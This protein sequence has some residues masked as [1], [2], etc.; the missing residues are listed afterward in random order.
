MCGIAGI[1]DFAGRPIGEDLLEAMA[2]SLRHRGPDDA[3]IWRHQEDG[4]SAGLAHARLAVIDP[5][6]QGHQP[7]LDRTGRWAITYNGELYNYRA[8]AARLPQPLRTA[9][10]T[11]VALE[12]CAAW[13]A[14]ALAAFDGMWAMAVVNPYDRRGHLSRDP[15]GIKPLFY[16]FHDRRLVFGSEL[17]ALRQVAD[18]PWDIDEQALA[19]Y[20]RLGWIP[21][22]LTIYRQVRK[23]APGHLLTFDA[24]GPAEPTRFFRLP[25]PAD[26][27]PAYLDACE[28]VRS[29]V[30]R[31][32]ESQ[33]VADVPLG[34][35]LSGGLDSS[36]VVACLARAC[37]RPV[38]TFSIGYP[39][40]DRY[41]ETGYARMVARH[42]GTEHQEIRLS[43]GDVLAAVEPTLDRLGEPFG[44]SSI[45]PT[46]LV[47]RHTRAA[48]TVALSGDG[49]DELFGGY[50]KYAGHAWLQRYRRLPA[51]VR[52]GFLEPLLR[53]LPDARST[54]LLDRVRQ[55]R[56][57]M[58]GDLEDPLESHL[59]WTLLTSEDQAAGLLGAQA[60][61]LSGQA[62]RAM[63]R[64][65]PAGWGRR[66]PAGA[67]EAILLA[68]LAVGLPADMLHKVD[69]ASMAHSLE[70]RVPL[71]QRDLVGLV[72]GLPIDYRI[73]GVLGKRI[74][75]DA[76]ADVLPGPVRFRPKM[77]FEVPV[78]EFLRS[79]L[80][81]MYRDL[82]NRPALEDLGLCPE[83]AQGLFEEH[84]S[85]R[86]DHSGLLW[87]L[88][89]LA[90]WKRVH[91]HAGGVSPSK[92]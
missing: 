36:V 4:F 76:F 21:H 83:A 60:A 52:K 18:L 67:L 79:E 29:A 9:C 33:R 15:M 30:E 62:V 17:A 14:S 59:A 27:P 42:L 48:V 2:R 55:A 72:T 25:E 23:L 78:G 49:G 89:V 32:V 46:A 84:L 86:R 56:K 57:L 61:R 16:A 24:A 8:L 12:A 90:R 43:F 74:L 5:T 19:C 41:D 47:S 68:D 45:L 28:L 69:A 70:V 64:E 31:A 26:P 3:G 91:R 92:V 11:E 34:A 7:M 51:A 1:I 65:A 38:R 54:R 6:P 20:L 71:L 82:V 77:G 35:F 58:L 13:G 10:D 53:R 63:Y 40:H 50:W 22:P 87:S 85:R 75:R 39:E 73:R 81:D 80:A 37:G 66:G 88:L 44:D